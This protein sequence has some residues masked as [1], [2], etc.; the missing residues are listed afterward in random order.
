MFCDT[1]ISDKV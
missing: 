1:D